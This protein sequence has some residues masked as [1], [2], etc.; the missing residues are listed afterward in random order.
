MGLA[1]PT[2]PFISPAL[3]TFPHFRI[4]VSPVASAHLWMQTLVDLLS[5]GS[6]S[7]V[8]W[9]TC[10]WV[11]SRRL[12]GWVEDLF[13]SAPPCPQDLWT[14]R[15]GKHKLCSRRT[16]KRGKFRLVSFYCSKMPRSCLA[17]LW[18]YHRLSSLIQIVPAVENFPR[19]NPLS[20]Y[21]IQDWDI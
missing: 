5:S 8:R 2:V 18:K 13:C 11:S 14:D 15:M 16:H 12:P 9:F 3:T 17:C 19:T 21:L 1:L 10:Y 7:V 20:S 6:H 4:Q